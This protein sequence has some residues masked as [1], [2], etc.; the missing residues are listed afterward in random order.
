MTWTTFPVKLRGSLTLPGI[1][2][3]LEP[4]TT[5][6][7]TCDLAP[8]GGY[9]MTSF[10]YPKRER[11]NFLACESHSQQHGRV[12]KQAWLSFL[13]KEINTNLTV[14]AKEAPYSYGPSLFSPTRSNYAEMI[15]NIMF[16]AGRR[17]RR[18]HGIPNRTE[19]PRLLV[20]ISWNPPFLRHQ[21]L[22]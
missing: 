13:L 3:K 14:W 11:L 7:C 21:M 4:I 10:T 2:F 9:R 8:C 19:N 5:A 18:R 15:G 17:R 1:F 12:T 22:P 20:P 6:T 16:W